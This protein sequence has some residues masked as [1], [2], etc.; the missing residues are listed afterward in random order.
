MERS[1]LS[2][3]FGRGSRESPLQSLSPEQKPLNHPIFAF[4]ND[5]IL[6]LLISHIKSLINEEFDALLTS[7]EAANAFKYKLHKMIF[8]SKE[9]PKLNEEFKNKGLSQ[10]TICGKIFF[11]NDIYIRCIDCDTHTNP[12]MISI[13]C[14]QCFDKSNHEGHRI[15]IIKKHSNSSAACD[16]G[17]A[18]EMN[19]D[20][21][22]PDHQYKEIDIEELL[23]IFPQDMMEKLTLG[24]N[25][26]FYCIISFFEI[27][28]NSSN[29]LI[30]SAVL[31]FA[32][33]CIDEVLSFCEECYSEISESFLPIF[34]VIFKASFSGP[35]NKVWHDCCD[36]KAESDLKKVDTEQSH[37]C[38][39]S[40][41]GNLFRIGNIMGVEQQSKLQK[42][43]VEGSKQ[44]KLKEIFLL[45][46]TKYLH[47]L[48]NHDYVSDND[49]EHLNSRLLNMQVQLYCRD[50]Q[51]VKV[52][53]IGNFQN[54][55]SIIRKA[56]YESIQVSSQLYSVLSDV[57]SALIYFLNPKYKSAEKLV[58]EYNLA[59]DL[60][61]VQMNF[62]IK[63]FYEAKIYIGVFEHLVMQSSI[64]RG[65]MIEKVLCHP[66]EYCLRL[67][68]KFPPDVKTVYRK[69]F[70]SDWYCNFEIAR[71]VV[72]A[73]FNEGAQNFH[74]GLERIFTSFIRNSLGKALNFEGIEGFIRENLP[75]K[76]PSVLGEMA[77]EGVL[78][79]LGMIRYLTL[80]HNFKSGDLWR[81]Y[82]FFNNVFFE[83]D[84]VSVQIMTVLL[85]PEKL[86]ETIV[87]NFFSYSTELQ[88]FF[89]KPE[90][91]IK[92][93]YFK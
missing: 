42:I 8:G 69:K 27:S 58:K 84:I 73:E 21:F 10:K 26:A 57:K 31:E 17:D 75:E 92:D 56:I 80:V 49:E 12:C 77:I 35:Y 43:L 5:E 93:D 38:K 39:C 48:Y 3:I 54:F 9:I 20:G 87:K 37:E 4:S 32:N 85:K 33:L 14:P 83:T 19:P 6:S 7:K 45:E 53:E 52:I 15:M 13:L 89:K 41:L 46:F 74:A 23:K 61:E 28:Q 63:F 91:I 34:G 76:E 25:K 22:C 2:K 24:L 79:S 55:I 18:N 90:G 65:F 72:Q 30:S 70:A 50:N 60:L 88:E 40:I 82:Y 16:C 68:E 36:L 81:V 11:E 64:N 51:L 44:T 71:E 78:H 86:F 47:F 67:I 62:Q 59:K 1:I 29:E 66:L